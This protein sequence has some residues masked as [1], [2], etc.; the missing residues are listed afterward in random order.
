[1]LLSGSV[2]ALP[3]SV[4]ELVGK[5]MVWSGP[6]LATGGLFVLLADVVT[7]S[8]LQEEKIQFRTILY[9]K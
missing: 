3:S 1:M 9:R 8:F 2:E 7:C 6:A 4:A 5:V